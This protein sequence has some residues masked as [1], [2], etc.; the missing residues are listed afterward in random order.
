M[1]IRTATP[2]LLLTVLW[3]LAGFPLK[4]LALADSQPPVAVMEDNSFFIEE[5]YNQEVGVVQHIFTAEYDTSFSNDP[6][7]EGWTL[8]F[9]QEWPLFSERHQV[10]YAIPVSLMRDGGDHQYGLSDI[11]L[12]YRFQ[13]LEETERVPAFAPRFTLILP[14]GSRDKQTGDGVVGY[15]WNLPFSKVL[16]PRFATHLNLGLTYLPDVRIP[17]DD[18]GGHLSPS[19]S[20]VNYNLGTSVIFALVP[21]FHFLVEWIGTFEENIDDDGREEGSFSSFIS[22]GFRAAVVNRDGLQIVMG[23]AAPIGLTRAA[24]DYGAFLYFSVEHNFM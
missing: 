7:E 18:S 2:G 19:H 8:Q 15:Q 20:L 22:P 3:V 6:D 11:Q 1:R 23:A 4:T 9:T 17:L 24:P 5:A 14:T 16:A 21:R 10:S 12:N 13:A